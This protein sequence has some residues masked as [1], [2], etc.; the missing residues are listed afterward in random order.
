L[1]KAGSVET[2][3]ARF[4]A[5]TIKNQRRKMRRLEER[6]ALSYDRH[7]A[8]TPAIP[9]RDA[10]IAGLTLK[11]AWLRD[12]GLV[13]RAFSDSRIE[14]FFTD[15]ITAHDRPSGV[16]V[17]MLRTGGEIAD[18]HIMVDCK[19]RRA[20]H[21][22]GYN[23]K[24]ERVGPGNIHLEYAIAKAFEEGLA[25]FD[26]LAPRHDYKMDWADGVVV[27]NDYAIGITPR[28][29]AYGAIYLGLIREGLKSAIKMLPKGL[30]RSIA[31]AQ[32]VLGTPTI[33]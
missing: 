15:A 13:S 31:K 16:G 11:R 14:G 7:S 24:F 30:T 22:L 33:A 4:N 19:D 18:H 32:R 23:L 17:S 20:L 27:V 28:G 6:G 21:V 3:L 25:T 29:R 10:V 1:K 8:H 26:F 9:A 2:F 12:K 5:K